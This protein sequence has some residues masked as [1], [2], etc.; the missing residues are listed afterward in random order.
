VLPGLFALSFVF[1]L[2]YPLTPLRCTHGH[3]T[4]P[5]SHT[6]FVTEATLPSGAHRVAL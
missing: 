5:A 2:L 4:P 1:Y 6:P 3:Q